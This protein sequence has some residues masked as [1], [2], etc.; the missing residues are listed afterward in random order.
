MNLFACLLLICSFIGHGQGLAKQPKPCSIARFCGEK[1]YYDLYLHGLPV[2][3]AFLRLDGRDT[4]R[5]QA[6][7]DTK[8]F[9]SLIFRIHNIYETMMDASRERPIRFNKLIQ[10]RNIS[11]NLQI[12][13]D[14]RANQATTRDG[15]SWE[16]LTGTQ[17]LF[18][19]LYQLRCLEYAPDDTVVYNLDVESQPWRAVGT[20]QTGN[21]INIAG[22]EAKRRIEFK[23]YSVGIPGQRAWKTDLL[24]NRI[25][26]GGNLTILLGSSPDNIPL[27][28][29]FG[30]GNNCVEM[31][32]TKQ[33]QGGRW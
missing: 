2:A 10:Q 28:I 13:Y 9:A 26:K 8:S 32:F 5:I 20:I 21:G 31:R 29:R 30:E 6:A 16:I 3:N 19:M 18:S 14:H 24:T 11:Q 4:L 7:I 22:I 33:L 15:T 1:L 25:T 23:F 12:T 17:N 27:L